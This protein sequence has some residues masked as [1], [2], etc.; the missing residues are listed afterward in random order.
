[1]VR[2]SDI[3]IVEKLTGEQ[4]EELIAVL[5]EDA[6]SF[7]LSY[8]MRTNIITPLKKSVRDLAIVALN[9][10]GTEGE[11]SRSE[12]GETYNFNDAPRQIFDILNRYRICR[13][14]GI[15]YENKKK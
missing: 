13:V 12:G 5:L 9:R 10:M 7:V 8:T 1:M 15:T 11:S 3:H 6:E 14:G 4:D 2:P